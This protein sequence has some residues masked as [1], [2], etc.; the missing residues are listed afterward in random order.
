[1]YL[2]NLEDNDIMTE[3]VPVELYLIHERLQYAIL[4]GECV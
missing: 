1:M 2:R 3:K 4:R